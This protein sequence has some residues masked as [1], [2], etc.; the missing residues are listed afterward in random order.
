MASFLVA[1]QSANRCK[2]PLIYVQAI[3]EP[4]SLMP[5]TN[6]KE[7]FADILRVP[8]L[9]QTKRLP[10][11]VTFHI[12]MRMRL[13]TS[14]QQPLAVHDVECTVLGFDHDHS[15]Y[16]IKGK[17]RTDSATEMTCTRM[18]KAIYVKLDDCDLIF[19]PPGTCSSHR[20][21][22]HDPSCEDCVSAVQLGV[23]AVKPLTRTWKYYLPDSGGKYITVTRT[24]FPLMPLESVALY[25]MQGTTADPGMF[26]YWMFPRRCAEEI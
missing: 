24:Q 6:A 14:I 11:V 21:Y 25:S 15:D 12:G 10:G 16:H 9:S 1:R 18:P 19:L 5:Q 7:L 4:R 20:M 22:G 23:F 26:A 2:Q 8:S 17:L 3:D 13:T